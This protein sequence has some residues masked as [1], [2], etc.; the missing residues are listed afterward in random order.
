MY[1]Y[2]EYREYA[3]SHGGIGNY[4]RYMRKFTQLYSVTI[5]LLGRLGQWVNLF[6]SRA[7]LRCTCVSTGYS[8]LKK[9]EVVPAPKPLGV[10][11]C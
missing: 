3:W 6:D 4:F 11:G 2:F 7:A 1:R 8:G 10:L 9:E 5:V